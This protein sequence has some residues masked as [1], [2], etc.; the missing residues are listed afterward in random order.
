MSYEQMLIIFLIIDGP[1]VAALYFLWKGM[2]LQERIW[3][4]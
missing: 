4:K 2:N 3:N 1:V